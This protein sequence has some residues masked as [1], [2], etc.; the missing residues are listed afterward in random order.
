MGA[1]TVGDDVQAS[2]KEERFG[3]AS[4]LCFA[5][6]GNEWREQARFVF[7]FCPIVLFFPLSFERGHSLQANGQVQGRPS[8]LPSLLPPLKARSSNTDRQ[9]DNPRDVQVS[10]RTRVLDHLSICLCSTF[11]LNEMNG[12]AALLLGQTGELVNVVRSLS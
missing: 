9:T 5:L 8:P 1:S 6:L 3:Q 10:A 12:C 4:L 11:G 7:T 2:I